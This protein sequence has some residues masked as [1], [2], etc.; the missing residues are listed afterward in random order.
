MKLIKSSLLV[1]S[2]AF[3]I[4]SCG[5]SDKQNT[6][7]ESSNDISILGA[8]SSFGFPIYSKV[9]S[10]YHNATG[11]KVNYQSI[12]SS[13]GIKQLTSKK[14]DFGGTDKFL[15]DED[16]QKIGAPIVHIPTCIGAI[17]LAYNLEGNPQINLSPEV[18]S[19]MYLGKITQWNDPKIQAINPDAKLPNQKITVVHR[20]DGSGTSYNY[21]LYLSRVNPEWESSVGTGASVKWPTG[22]GGKG[23]EGI[24]G[25]IQQTPG[26]IG[27]VEL[28]YAMQTGLKYAS[29]Q[30]AAGNFITPSLEA[31]KN[32]ANIDLPAD[33]RIY[34][35]NS[36]AT[37]AYPISSFT[38]AILY[39]EQNYNGRTKEQA[40]ALVKALWWLT[41]QGQEFCEP[42]D[43]V[44]LPNPAVQV[45]EKALL[46]IT[47]DGQALL[48]EAP[49]WQAKK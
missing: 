48:T 40:T 2:S 44:R 39:K 6:Q 26:S 17:A 22:V 15:T 10:E 8:G 14:V 9:F 27:Y 25:I 24:A 36:E 32:S 3:L 42:L 7:K 30:N 12:G 43:Y 49:T 31:T 34:I 1:L 19:A 46:S 18:L 23:N 45:A 35:I 37:D 21:T 47:F 11:A 29:I 16:I 33:S 13:G 20:S 28:V 4:A 5:G 38:W 41:H